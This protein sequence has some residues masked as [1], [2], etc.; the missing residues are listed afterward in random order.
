MIWSGKSPLIVG[1]VD[2][3]GKVVQEFIIHP[4]QEIPAAARAI[5]DDNEHVYSIDSKGS[6]QRSDIER[7]FK[8]KVL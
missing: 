5:L 2:E 3:N 4:G 1:T 8:E 7:Y 6:Y